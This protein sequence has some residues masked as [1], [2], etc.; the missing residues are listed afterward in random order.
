MNFYNIKNTAKVALLVAFPLLAAGIT[1]CQD[2]DYESFP[3]A[4][5]PIDKSDI[6]TSVEGNDFV[7]TW[8][9]LQ[10]GLTM[11]LTRYSDGTN[12]G[13]VDVEGTRYVHENVETQVD[14]SYVLKVKDSKGNVS[15]GQVINYKRPG[16]KRVESITLSQVDKADGYDLNVEWTV[17]EDAETI[18][19]EATNGQRTIKEDFDADEE[20]SFIIPDVKTGEEWN[21]T[22]IAENEEGASLPSTA[23]LKI[24]KTQIG[25][26]SLYATEEELLENGDDDE[27][28][29]WLW[30][31]DEYPTAKLVYFGDITSAASVEPFRVLF[32]MRDIETDNEDDVF[33]WSEE[34]VKATPFIKQWYTDG[35]NLLLWS[36]AMTYI[37]QLG[38]VPEGTI[39]SNDR[40]INTGK[41]NWN[42]DTWS[43]AV[44]SYPGL[45]FKIDY[46]NHPIYRGLEVTE[47]DRIKRIKF[48]GAGFTEDHNCLFFNWPGQLTGKGNQDK[49]CYDIVTKEYGIYPLGTWDN[50]QIEYISQL[51]VWEAQKGNTEFNGT[52]ICI[53]NGGC[54]FSMKN[55]DG[56]PDISAYP[57]NNIYQD[58][59]LTLAK[60]SLE[61]LKTR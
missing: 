38:R 56:T 5:Q 7:I 50:E 42:P 36:H 59:I 16:A 28:C 40:N 51:N 30:L 14:Y 4:V 45:K 52:I 55:E 11:E 32:F 15:V 1:S 20:D 33:T 58:N 48:K 43:L 49:A 12:G 53:G 8:K 61:Y 17:N 54:N 19:L 3:T 21:I 26:L 23:S 60:N 57:K 24:G 10:K 37:E 22:L 35:G 25:Y 41:G 13:S 31:K 6:K 47:D 29:A 44:S 27:A 39:R 46:S 2:K 34:V 18:K 9:E